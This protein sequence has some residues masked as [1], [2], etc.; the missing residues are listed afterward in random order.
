MGQRALKRKPRDED[1]AQEDTSGYQACLV[2]AAEDD[3]EPME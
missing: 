2:G 3:E 1:A